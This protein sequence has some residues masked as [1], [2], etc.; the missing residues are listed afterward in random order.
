MKTYK[1]KKLYANY[2]KEIEQVKTI[3]LYGKANLFRKTKK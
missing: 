1:Q 2:P 3:L